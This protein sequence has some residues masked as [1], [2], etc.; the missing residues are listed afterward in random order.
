ML[1]ER[2]FWCLVALVLLFFYRPLFSETFFF[3]DVYLL[4]YGKKVLFAEALKSGQIP[5]WDPLMNGGQPFLASPGTSALYPFNVL[6]LLLSPLAA[7]NL[8][9]VLQFVV[10]A[11]SAY[12][13]ARVLDLSATAAFVCGAVYTFCGYVLSSSTLLV[14]MQA[15]PWAPAL[16]G[17]MH[18][19][20]REQRKRWL[21]LAAVFGALPILGGGA[22]MSAM[23]FALA[24]AWAL[25]VPGEVP[26]ARRVKLAALAMAFS[27][28]L[29]LMLT[30][31]AY[32]VIR[33]SSRG[34]KREYSTF[35]QWSVSPR[36]LP[37]LIVPRF[38]GP[39]DTLA[40]RDYWGGPFEYG[41]PYVVSIYFGAGAFLLAFAGLIAPPL[42][43]RARILL[44]TFAGAGFLLC[45][46][47]YLPFFHL[48][49]D[50][51]PLI[52]VFRFP[53]KALQM[54]LVPVAVLSAA[55]LDALATARRKIVVPAI[56]VAAM[57]AVA[58]FFSSGIAGAILGFDLRPESAAVLTHSF[59]HASIAAVLFALALLWNRRLAVAAV[60]VLDLAVAGWRVNPYASRELFVAPPLA[61][62]VKS[63]IGEGRLYRTP[64]PFVQRLNVPTN[65]GVW[66]AWWD[67]QLL[68]RYTAATF[69]IPL[70]FHE[71]Y[72]GLAPTRMARM[73]DRI[74]TMSWPERLPILSQ[75]G[76]SVIITPDV[77]SGEGIER[78]EALR[79]ANGLPLYVYRNHAATP[80]RMTCG[81]ATFHTLRRRF[82]EWSVDVTSSCSG[83]LVFADSWYPG[84]R[85]TVD[86]R[87][88]PQLLAGFGL[89]AVAVPAGHHVVTKRY[90]PRL[91][92]IGLA[93][94][95]L[96][97]LGLAFWRISQ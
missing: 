62:K 44:G 42:P 80:L 51:V 67:L 49:Y 71:D 2:A 8:H 86:E 55:G 53:V 14:L 87:D 97:A 61:A 37:E 79:G 60:V 56:V 12:F 92:L 16:L 30:L 18:L 26:L 20:V 45:I 15:V 19:L 66:L 50:H 43:P 21:V 11:A 54:T 73:T 24:G 32:E 81:P 58:T 95:L 64:D 9:L 46:G 31:P 72:D 52:G 76:A 28:G 22:D 25:V 83:S 41:F 1:G 36:R 91:P 77:V 94:S 33:N 59:V 57:L 4:F 35:V 34:E 70:I 96:T 85:M 88:S 23:S 17:A 39:T 7:F 63:I 40:R 29:S 69:G 78:V 93:G 48:L 38:F 27:I 65:E 90:Q 47:G 89:S 6:F 13:L 75:A 10:C 68:S 3:R 82:N 5:L 84:W 74:H